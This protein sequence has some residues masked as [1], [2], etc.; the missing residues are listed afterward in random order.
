MSDDVKVKV[1]DIRVGDN[2]GFR[3]GKHYKV[4]NIKYQS[5]HG[6]EYKT[7]DGL[8]FMYPAN[9]TLMVSAYGESHGREGHWYTR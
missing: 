1:G 8:R 2:V 6:Y 9:A 3:P 5:G 4:T 7:A